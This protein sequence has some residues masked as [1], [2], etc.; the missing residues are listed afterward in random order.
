MPKGKAGNPIVET[1]NRLLHEADKSG[2]FDHEHGD[3]RKLFNKTHDQFKEAAP[4]QDARGLW[5]LTTTALLEN[6]F[7]NHDIEL[8][9]HRK[10]LQVLMEYLHENSHREVLKVLSKL[11]LQDVVMIKKGKSGS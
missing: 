2:Y 4:D 3:F 8:A 7:I 6:R 5:M 9:V 1:Y 10:I 11:R